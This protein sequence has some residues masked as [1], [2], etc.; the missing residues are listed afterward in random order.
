MAKK[1]AKTKKKMGR[2][3]K[4]TKKL[5]ALICELIVDGHTLR[6]LAAREDMPSV[7][8]I[9]RWLESHPDF[10]KQ[11]TRAKELQTEILVDEMRTIAFDGSLDVE[12]RKDRHGNEY[13]ATRPDIVQR[14]K[15]MVDTI[16]WQ[17]GKLK[18]KKYGDKLDLNHSGKIETATPTLRISGTVP[19]SDD[20]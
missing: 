15:L 13:D 3:S 18:P 7:P 11:Y 12:K 1:K 20:K 8:A 6:Q 16:K 19:Q 9:F 4:Y 5:A 2:P 14:S 10:R 17:A